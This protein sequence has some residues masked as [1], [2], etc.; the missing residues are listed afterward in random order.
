MAAGH[1]R[2][3][4][5][6][7][8]IVGDTGYDGPRLAFLLADLPVRVLVRVRSDRVMAY[9]AAPRRPVRG[10]EPSSSSRTPAH[11]PRPPTPR[12]PRPRDT[13]PRKLVRGI[14]CI[15]S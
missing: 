10:T 8:W 2:E 5:P 6:E 11:G 9:P 3:G 1:W 14:D 12:L 4:D 13:A 7:I 15:P